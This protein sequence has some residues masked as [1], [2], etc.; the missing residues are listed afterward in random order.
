MTSL[1][2]GVASARRS[3]TTSARLARILIGCAAWLV[4]TSEAGKGLP[5]ASFRSLRGGCPGR[6]REE[7]ACGDS[8]QMP[9]AAEA[10]PHRVLLSIGGHMLMCF[11]SLAKG[12]SPAGRPTRYAQQSLVLSNATFVRL[13]LAPKNR[14]YSSTLPPP[15]RIYSSRQG[16]GQTKTAHSQVTVREADCSVSPGDHSCSQRKGARGVPATA[17]TIGDPRSRPPEPIGSRAVSRARAAASAWPSRS[18]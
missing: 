18:R 9:I 15:P 1:R 17:R 8:R 12:P 11:A 13:P 16:C 10:A 2:K 6:K 14:R 7:H 3:S 5:P 4:G